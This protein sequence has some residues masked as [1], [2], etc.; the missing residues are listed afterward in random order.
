MNRYVFG[1]DDA[2][3]VYGRHYEDIF[4][5]ATV[6]DAVKAAEENE[7]AIIYKLVPVKRVKV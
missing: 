5:F 2:E 7:G 6:R 4:C 3:S 1:Y